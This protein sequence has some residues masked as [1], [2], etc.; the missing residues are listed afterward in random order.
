MVRGVGSIPMQLQICETFPTF[1]VGWGQERPRTLGH[2]NH[3]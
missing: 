2:Q 1:F 3:A